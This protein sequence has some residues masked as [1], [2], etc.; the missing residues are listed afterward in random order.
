MGQARDVMD[1]M[2]TLAIEERD[3]PLATECYAEN[4][5]IITPDAGERR[6]RDEIADYLSQFVDS[7]TDSHFEAVSKHESGNAAIDEGYFV[8]TNTAPL[9]LPTGETMP[10]T[11]RTVRVR[12]C[13]VATVEGG[14]ITEHRFY[15]DQ[16]DFLS[17]LGLMAE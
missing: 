2:T 10:A 8:G 5:V 6:G 12:S 15:F 17:Q 16:V 9:K 1:R 13:D 14:R 11:G 7:F 3:L 4:A